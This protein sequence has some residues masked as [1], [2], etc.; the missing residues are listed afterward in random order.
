ML[1]LEGITVDVEGGFLRDDGVFGGV[2]IDGS[3]FDDFRARKVSPLRT[4]R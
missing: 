1:A 2:G 3:K 4:G